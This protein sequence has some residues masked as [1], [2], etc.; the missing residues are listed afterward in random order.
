MKIKTQNLTQSALNWAVGTAEGA[1]MDGYYGL[2]DYPYVDD[3]SLSGPLV[4]REIFSFS[5]DEL[6]ETR[7]AWHKDGKSRA[8]GPTL[9]IACL[10][11]IVASRLGDEVDVPDDVL[12]LDA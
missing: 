1:A 8:Y 9:L 7:Y 6:S 10:R 4:D 3:W 2:S 5:K 11:C 12:A